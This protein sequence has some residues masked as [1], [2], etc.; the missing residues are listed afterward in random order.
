M[1]PTA[2]AYHKAES[3][4]DA[5]SMLAQYGDDAKILAGG[6]S[7]IPAMKLRLN[8]PEHLIDI[9]KIADI[10]YIREEGNEIV[11]GAGSTHAD[12]ANSDL[13]K[14]KL[15]VLAHVAEMIGDRQ[16]RNVGTLGGSLAHADP[17]ADWPA[18]MLATDANMVIQGAGSGRHV[19]STDFFTGFFSTDLQDNELLTAIR[20]P[21]PNGNSVFTYEKFFQPA[22]RFAIVGCA[23]QVKHF[24]GAVEDARVAFT[25][26][27]DGA[28]RATAVEN[29]LKGVMLNEE[30]IT[31][32]AQHAVEGVDVMEDHF[33]SQEYRAH[34]A[35]VYAKRALMAAAG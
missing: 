8:Q 33:A 32:A 14:Q 31:A 18:A 34:L 15:P 22:S 21:V 23:V 26:V 28:Y 29:A 27:S 10:R 25:G 30:N 3:V 24:N 20:I 19:A 4:S 17:A 7:L 9:S 6:H 13:V 1:L 12:I 5:L 35:K 11:I 2:F 16:V